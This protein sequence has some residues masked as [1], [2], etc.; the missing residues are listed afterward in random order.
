MRYAIVESGGKQYKAVEGEPIEVDRLPVETGET[1]NLSRVLMLVDG[2]TSLVGTP[3]VSDVQ[4]SATVMEH[5]KGPKVVI[6]KYSP[7]KRIRVKSGHRQ[8]YTRLMVDAIGKAGES[9]KPAKAAE[10]PAAVEAGT[11][12]E[13]P[14]SQ[15]KTRKTA[16]PKTATVPSE[17][18]KESI[19]KK[20]P[21]SSKAKKE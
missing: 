18:K 20:S 21:A 1:V 15:P 5:F 10:E 9:R 16:G 19:E 2:D 12:P 8:Q 4:V 17:S 14:A 13:K 6:F 11:L 3:T 7:K